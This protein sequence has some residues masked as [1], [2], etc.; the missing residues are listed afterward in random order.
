MAGSIANATPITRPSLSTSAPPES[1]G[2]RSAASTKHQPPALARAVDVGARRATISS[3]TRAGA[4]AQRPAA[5]V[6]VHRAEVADVAGAERQRRRGRAR[7]RAGPRGPA[8]GRTRRRRRRRPRRSCP[9]RVGL[10]LACDDVRVGHDE[11][12]R[13]RP[14]RSPPGSGRTPAAPPSRSTRARARR[15]RRGSTAS[16]GRPGS[17]GSS[18]RPSADGYGASE[19][20][21][22][23]AGELRRVA[24][25]ATRRS[26]A[27]LVEPRGHARGPALRGRERRDRSSTPAPARRRRRRRRRRSGPSGAAARVAAPTRC[28]SD[29]D[30]EAE[31][32]PDVRDSTR[33]STATVTRSSAL[34]AAE[35]L[36]T[37]AAT[38]ARR[39]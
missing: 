37:T 34:V 7:R 24:S 17:G 38:K 33:N 12:G 3:P 28:T 9:R 13:R 26:T 16:G 25:G 39:G 27:R 30:R 35:R 1:P 32:L 22:P 8:R 5:R 20:A 14:S 23:H 29:A 4:A 31:R 19:I 10:V 6:A 2:A 18:R 15:P 21:R 36:V 11:P